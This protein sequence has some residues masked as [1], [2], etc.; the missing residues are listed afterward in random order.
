MLR[1]ILI[2]VL[3]SCLAGCSSTKYIPKDDKLYT[4]ATVDLRGDSLTARDRKVL[5]SNLQGLTRPKP[6]SAFLGIPFK[7]WMWNFFGGDSARE[8][9]FKARLRDKLGQRPVLLSEVDLDRNTKVLSAYLQNKGFFKGTVAGD[10]VVK[11]RTAKAVYKSEAGPLYRIAAVTFEQDSSE[12]SRN[13]QATAPNTLLKV[14][15]PF[16][17]DVIKTERTRI[18][19][20][21]KEHGFYYFSPEFL[22]VKVDSTIG[23]SKVDL[24]VT[25]KPDAPPSAR[26]AYTINDVFIYSNYSLNTADIDTNTNNA[27]E[28][29]GYYI[30][31]PN[32]TYRPRLLEHTMQ[33]RPGETYNRNDHN[34]T[35]NRLIN[36]N[37]FK[38]VK[39]RFEPVTWADSP[40]LNA[41]YYLTPLPKK[42]LRTEITGLTK[43]N[44][45]NGSEITFSWRN[46]NT[47]RGGE[48]LSLSAY[49][50]S[51]I[52]FA[53][54]LQGFNIFRTG[55]E[56][57]LTFPRFVAPFVD[58]RNEGAFAPR[59]V[60]Q[61]GYDILNRRQLF[62]L[63]SFRG[64]Y[65]Y[66]WRRGIL[67]QHEFYPISINYVQPFN[68]TP[69]FEEKRFTVPGIIRP[70]EVQFIL[71]STYRFNYN[72]S[73]KTTNPRRWFY[74]NGIADVSGNV[75][76]LINPGDVKAGDTA[77]FF[78]AA[79]AQ[80]VKL[81]TEGRYY[82][83]IGLQNT[84][85][86]RLIIGWSNPYGNST[87]MPFIKQYFAGGNN[88]LRAFRSRNVGPGTYLDTSA[89][90]VDQTGDYKLEISTE[91]RPHI[92]GPL[93]GALFVDAGNVWLK[94]PDPSRPGAEF[95][96]K[97][98]SQLAVG[99]GVGIR[100]DVTVFVIRLDAAFPLRK[101]WMQNPWVLQNIDII[102]RNWR[103][104]N[105]VYNLAIGYPF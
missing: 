75:A 61:A 15:D 6:N 43:S 33:F 89:I 92:S 25:V 19:A 85:A 82:R 67:R 49:V 101:P 1:P 102:N 59:T 54:T 5:R 91:Y 45:S 83:R 100:V 14:N 53:G 96:N 23:G 99:A 46:R 40:R 76:G 84:W 93:Y 68:T 87:A 22:L 56:A 60:I 97:F 21:L 20:Y 11:A 65:G 37:L 72:G 18:D 50:G 86:N 71:G 29:K 62:T 57:T 63:N 94:N 7:L 26:R 31:D 12:L 77:R 70:T 88:S 69:L 32:N 2:A 48:Q 79:Y 38:F 58:I 16:D 64:Q 39:N 9:S 44:N 27:I 105:V 80:Y 95:T 81:E 74:F 10:T 34:V 35:L 47:F 17:L 36:L 3:I 41:Y 4:G 78:G 98:L 103:R 8:G 13:M 104:E 42:T 90:L 24:Y 55:V 52:Q 30:V 28:Y 66:T 73:L 51:E